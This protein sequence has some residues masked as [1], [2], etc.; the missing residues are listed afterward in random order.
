MQL[1]LYR[2]RRIFRS[3]VCSHTTARH[4][5][6]Q[7]QCR[8]ESQRG[9][10]AYVA[11]RKFRTTKPVAVTT[12][13]IR[14]YHP[15]PPGRVNPVSDTLSHFVLPEDSEE[16][17]PFVEVD[18][19]IPTFNAGMTFPDVSNKLADDVCA[20][21]CDHNTFVMFATTRNPIEVTKES[22]RSRALRTER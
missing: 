11:D 7:V 22:P 5:R 14:L 10:M 3:V 18:E 6:Y 20:A 8:Q 1:Q 21:S 17:R 9:L 15:V 12:A 16:T 2:A 4:R 19:Y 13:R